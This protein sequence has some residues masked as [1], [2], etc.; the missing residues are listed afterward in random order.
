MAGKKFNKLTVH[1]RSGSCAE[2]YAKENNIP[3]EAI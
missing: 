3:F 2:T 1:A